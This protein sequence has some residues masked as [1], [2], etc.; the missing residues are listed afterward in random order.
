M[1][2]DIVFYDTEYT[3]WDGSLERGWS[4]DW[5]EKEII[6]IGAVGYDP[7]TLKETDH[8]MMFIKPVINPELSDYFIDLTG[9]AQSQVD[10]RGIDLN[11]GMDKFKQFIGDRTAYS[12][13][14]DYRVINHNLALRNYRHLTLN[15]NQ[16]RDIR[17]WAIDNSVPDGI[18]S[19]ELA[20]HF[21]LMG[22]MPDDMANNPTNNHD[23]LYDAQSILVTMRH[24]IKNGAEFPDK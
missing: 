1:T 6:Q 15:T 9:I 17:P 19:G 21:G 11:T 10:D 23:A 18:N 20:G 8:F 24:L 3:C 16:Y 7:D 2:N 12:W 22:D 5:E 14:S 4:K 13:G